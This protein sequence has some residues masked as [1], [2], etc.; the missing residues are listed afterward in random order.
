[1]MPIVF[2]AMRCLFTGSGTRVGAGSRIGAGMLPPIQED[3]MIDTEKMY[4]AGAALGR[5][6][7]LLDRAAEAAFPSTPELAKRRNLLDE[8]RQLLAQVRQVIGTAPG[9]GYH[10]QPGE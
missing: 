1:M 9:A 2:Q 7:L 3:T 10:A 4:E 8:A 5:A 6:F